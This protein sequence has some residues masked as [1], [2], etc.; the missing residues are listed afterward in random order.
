V[1]RLFAAALLLF[2]PL[3]G[4]SNSAL[5]EVTVQTFS[6]GSYQQILTAHKG[7]PMLLVLWSLECPPC[8]EEFPLLKEVAQ[9][10]PQISVVLISVD[11]KEAINEVGEVLEHYE[12]GRMEH[13]VFS[14]HNA[15]TLRHEVDPRWYGELPR[16][17]L[18]DRQQQRKARSGRTTR[19]E[20]EKWLQTLE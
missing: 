18:F 13:W 9:R 17:Y 3:T 11:G 5:A 14:N 16:L 10:Y 2:A 12:M 6:S 7:H 19:A 8:Q 20:L 4:Q 15:Q 1:N